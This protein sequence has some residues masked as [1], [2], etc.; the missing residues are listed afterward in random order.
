MPGTDC[1]ASIPSH[2]KTGQ[3]PEVNKVD[4]EKPNR[5]QSKMSVYMMHR[6]LL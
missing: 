6:L 4:K 1:T 2:G 3:L 5:T